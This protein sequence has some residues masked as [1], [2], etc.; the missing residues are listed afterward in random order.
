MREAVTGDVREIRDVH[1]ASIE[2]LAE[3]TYT[4]GQVQAWTHDRDP[5]EYPIESEQTDFIVAEHGEE[6]VEF[7][8]IKP[9]AD[10]YFQTDIDGEITAIYVHPIVA[11]NDVGTRIYGE[12]EAEAVRE[13]VGSL[14][15]WASLNAVPFYE[16]Q[17]YTG[18]TDHTHEYHDETLTVV[19]M[20]KRSIR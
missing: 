2:G 10:D 8:W 1:I 18:V 4:D 12:L 13:G 5:T 6:I 15:L 19:E 20:E 7:G 14:G 16:A 3:Q 11:R 9:D 17:G